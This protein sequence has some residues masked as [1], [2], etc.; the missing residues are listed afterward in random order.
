MFHTFPVHSPHTHARTHSSVPHNPCSHPA[1]MLTRPFTNT[2]APSSPPDVSRGVRG[3]D[4]RERVR[5]MV[6]A[7][8]HWSG[9]LGPSRKR[10][11]AAINGRGVVSEAATEDTYAHTCIHTHTHIDTQCRYLHTNTQIFENTRNQTQ[12]ADSTL[13]RAS[14]VWTGRSADTNSGLVSTG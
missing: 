5:Q 1:H 8:A 6:Q 14:A 4:A 3:V 12:S 10:I 2:H 9:A 13:S 7:K 11:D